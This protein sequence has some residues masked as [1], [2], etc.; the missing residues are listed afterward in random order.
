[1]FPLL[2][3]S[4]MFV[5]FCFPFDIVFQDKTTGCASDDLVGQTDQKQLTWSELQG[6][7]AE[8][9]Q[10]TGL[11]QQVTILRATVQSLGMQMQ[12]VQSLGKQMQEGFATE[13]MRRR[14]DYKN[15]EKTM[16]A[17]MDEGFKSE[18]LARQQAKKDLDV[19]KEEMKK[20]L[21]LRSEATTGVSLQG[22]AFAS[23]YSEIFIP[24]KMEFNGLVTDYKQCNF[25][26]LTANE[27]TIF[28]KDLQKMVPNE[29]HKYIDWDQTRT[30]QGTCPTKTLVW[31]L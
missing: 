11:L 22:P 29:F 5:H 2:H 7:R 23:K 10:N 30:E 14:E 24:R 1:M 4:L 26:V 19:L 9:H 18:Q 13:S 3:H 12:D 20:K 16:T 25:Q 15:M 31:S 8:Q 27:V 6:S 28:I 17:K 21:K